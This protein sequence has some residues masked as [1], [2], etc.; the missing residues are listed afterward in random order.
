MKRLGSTARSWRYVLLAFMLAPLLLALALDRA[1][2]RD[3]AAF[4]YGLA[5]RQIADGVYVLERHKVV[6]ETLS[7][8]AYLWHA[9]FVV[10][11]LS[12]IAMAVFF[13]AVMRWIARWRTVAAGQPQGGEETA[14]QPEAPLAR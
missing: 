6:L 4:D 12:S 10:R 14:G 7:Q 9:S 8:Q 5:P 2:A 13:A 3:S 11:V 1:H